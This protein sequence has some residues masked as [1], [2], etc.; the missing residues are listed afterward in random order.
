MVGVGVR[1]G[2]CWRQGDPV[3]EGA[4][5]MGT[6]AVSISGFGSVK[7]GDESQTAAR[8]LSCPAG[9]CSPR[10]RLPRGSETGLGRV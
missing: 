6:G 3:G 7:A 5:C 2:S 4:F 1:A 10:A 9:R 8:K